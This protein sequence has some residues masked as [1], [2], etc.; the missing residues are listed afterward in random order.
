MSSEVPVEWL[1]QRIDAFSE[2]VSGSTPDTNRL[3]YWDGEIT[4]ITPDD[5]SSNSQV[6]IHDSARK[7]SKLGLKHSSAQIIPKNSI[8]MSSRAPIGY[9]AIVTSDYT[10][11][12]GCKSLRLH[13]SVNPEFVYYSLLFNIDKIK[14]KGEGTTFAE[15][16]KKE[17]EKVS[18]ILPKSLTEQKKIGLIL[19]SVDIALEK[20]KD[21]VGKYKRIKEGIMVDLFN[22]GVDESGKLNSE[23]KNVEDKKIPKKWHTGSI[24]TIAFINPPKIRGLSKDTIVSFVPMESVS[25]EGQL[26]H[27]LSKKYIEVR[28][29][30]TSFIENDVLFAKITP[31]MEN[32]KGAFAKRLINGVG[33][34]ST[35]FHVLRA[36]NGNNPEFLYYLSTDRNLRQRAEG[37]MTGTAGQQRVPKK[38]FFEYRINIPENDEQKRIATRLRSIDEKIQVE[39]LYL[40]K[41]LKI[42]FGLLKDLITGKVRVVT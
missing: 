42:K 25:T 19:R 32:G 1:V 12:Q 3:A 8:V 22:K 33:L 40:R 36:K 14:Q 38:F 2:V 39:E 30:F 16:S 4:W 29:G 13:D 23:F 9:L 21:I 20:A 37:K 24:A 11:N 26:E 15:I 35:E 6:Y 27:R 10:T 31:C 28:K 41:L 7:I 5:L 18:I 34:G 17:L